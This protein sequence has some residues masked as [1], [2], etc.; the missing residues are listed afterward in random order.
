[1]LSVFVH[2]ISAFPFKLDSAEQLVVKKVVAVESV[3]VDAQGKPVRVVKD[4]IDVDL[5]QAS[6]NDVASALAASRAKESLSGGKIPVAMDPKG[7]QP[8]FK[9]DS[10][11]AKYCFNY[12]LQHSLRQLVEIVASNEKSNNNNNVLQQFLP[13]LPFSE[14]QTLQL[15]DIKQLK[16]KTVTFDLLHL[17]SGIPNKLDIILAAYNQLSSRSLIWIDGC[18]V[19][20]EQDKEECQSVISTLK[21]ANWYHVPNSS[22]EN[23]VVMTRH[24][25]DDKRALLDEILDSVFEGLIPPGSGRY[26]TMRRAIE[27]AILR[28]AKVFV[29]TGTARN[30]AANCGG[31]GCSTMILGRLMEKLASLSPASAPLLFTV[32]ILPQAIGGAK[33]AASRVSSRISYHTQDSLKFLDAFG[34][35][36]DFLYLDS[37]DF[38]ASNPLPS[39]QHHLKELL[40]AWDKLHANTVIIVD[41][42]GLSSMGKCKLVDSHLLYAGWK[43]DTDGYQ[44]VYVKN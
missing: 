4:L 34:Q 41:D 44:R 14:S 16:D 27:L 9:S 38:D 25:P 17:A 13:L 20:A 33:Q 42:C 39:Q 35:P 28:G 7:A 2:L 32:D 11:V 3:I 12:S 26:G 5:L 24:N 40:L 18:N 10:Q 15:N 6:N 37:Y 21:A 1:M 31:D 30:G 29:E 43:L 23:S 36:I 22:N 19:A 8:V